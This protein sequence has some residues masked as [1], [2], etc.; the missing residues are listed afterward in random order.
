M[1]KQ[2]KEKKIQNMKELE[3]RIKITANKTLKS[4]YKSKQRKNT[5]EREPVWM[6]EQI[7]TEIKERKRRNNKRRTAVCRE[8]QKNGKGCMKNKTIKH[9]KSSEKKY[10]NMKKK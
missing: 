4:K 3:E 7:Q 9:K 1:E 5:E 8:E 6:T 2:G 10:I